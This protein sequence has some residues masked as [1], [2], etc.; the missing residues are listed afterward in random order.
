MKLF[1]VLC[2]FAL[3]VGF[4][5]VASAEVQNVKVSGDLGMYSFWRNDYDLNDKDPNVNEAQNWFMTIAELQVDADLT[6]NVATCIRLFNQREWDDKDPEYSSDDQYKVE[7][8][9]AY[10]VLKEMLYS[11][12][13]LTVGR[14]DLWLGDGLVVGAKF[15][16]PQTQIIA[17]EYS[18]MTSFDAIRA[19]LDYDPWTID[20]IYSKIEENNNLTGGAAGTEQT[21]NNDDADLWVANVGYVFDSYNAEA[22]AYYVYL[23]DRTNMN[24]AATAIED[25]G[26]T[27][28]CLGIRGSFDP[29]E[30]GTIKGEIA[31]QLGDFVY[32][33]TNVARDRKAYALDIVG[34]YRFD[35]MRWAPKVT[36]E[37]LY[38]SGETEDEN[39]DT[40]DWEGWHQLYC[41]KTTLAIRQ[42]QNVFYD[43]DYRGASNIDDMLMNADQD[44]GVSNTQMILVSGEIY[45]T[46]SLTIGATYG[47]IRLAQKVSEV[48]TD[49]GVGDEIDITLTYDYTEDVTFGL[50]AAWFFP[51]DYFPSDQDDNAVDVVGSLNVSF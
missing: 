25:T 37:Y 22:E 30:Q 20:L 43:T 26:N 41:G 14:Q 15:N 2:I 6:D 1:K 46:E 40:D 10:V 21:G 38:L 39:D 24:T 17:D 29:V 7:I 5:T 4:A 16:D 27:V 51:G 48:S 23:H 47:N 49:K 31:L 3:V 8:D 36:V 44:S 11:P 35:D 32:D 42:W 12:L 50:L 9:L 19:T 45:P 34:E 13:T 18:A 33:G 28:D